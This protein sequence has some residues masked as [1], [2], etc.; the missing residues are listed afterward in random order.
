MNLKMGSRTR[1]ATQVRSSIWATERFDQG[2]D[3]TWSFFSRRL[4]AA[5]REPNA[6]GA[7]EDAGK[8]VS[9]AGS[10]W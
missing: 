9:W 4:R 3:K 5:R 2:I 8:E 10:S 7:R 6:R 1:G